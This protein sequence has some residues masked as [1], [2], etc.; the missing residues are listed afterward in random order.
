MFCTKSLSASGIGKFC[1]SVDGVEPPVATTPNRDWNLSG[2]ISA[3]IVAA[4]S[5]VGRIPS[6]CEISFVKVTPCWLR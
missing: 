6:D 1:S 5:A 2:S 4:P 3:E